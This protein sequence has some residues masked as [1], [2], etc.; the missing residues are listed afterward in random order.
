MI[1]TTRCEPPEKLRATSGYHWLR[2]TDGC[3]ITP[4]AI[5]TWCMPEAVWRAQG[6][7]RTPE[8]MHHEW[9]TAV[10]P[11]ADIAATD[12]WQPIATAPRDGT[13]IDLWFAGQWNKRMCEFAWRLE[14]WYSEYK[15][16]AYN[17][18]RVITHWR[19]LP[20]GPKETGDEG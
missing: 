15:I 17:D 7:E 1:G 13:V 10:A 3:G 4:P 2:R 6:I 12:S 14:Y 8:D 19:P 5:W 20:A 16:V 9:V 18:S 11:P